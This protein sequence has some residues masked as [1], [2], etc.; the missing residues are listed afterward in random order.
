MKYNI[1]YI[2]YK[3]INYIFIAYSRRLRTYNGIAC[4]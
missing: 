1:K 4:E 2:I 3:Y